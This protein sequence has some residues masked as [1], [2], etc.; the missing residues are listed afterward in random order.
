MGPNPISLRREKFEC[1]HPGRTPHNDRGRGWSDAAVGPGMSIF[2][3]HHPKSGRRKEGPSLQVSEGA[4][5]CGHLISDL[6]FPEL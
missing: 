1:R 3:G 6:Q 4:R 2:E 5:L